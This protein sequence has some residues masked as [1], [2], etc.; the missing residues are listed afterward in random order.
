MTHYVLDQDIGQSYA[1]YHG[2]ST[3]VI[4][5]I[6]DGEVHL[7]ISS[8]PFSDQY[9][10]SPSPRDFGNND[11]DGPFFAQMAYL[12]PELYRVTQPGRWAIVHAKD[13][14][15]YGSKAVD[16]V[17]EIEPF[18]DRCIV[19]MRSAGFKFQGRITVATDPVR[20]N[21]QTNRLTHGELRKDSSKMGVGMPEYL[22]LFRRPPSDTSK[23]YSD[24]PVTSCANTA[25]YSLARWQL[26]AASDWRS[27]GKRLLQPYE[28]DGYD[29][30]AH[31][32]HLESL[33]KR[34]LLGRANGQRRPADSPW[35]WWDIQ[36]TDVLN[37]DIQRANGEPH[38]CPLMLDLIGRCIQRWSNASELVFD[39]F[40]GI[41]SVPYVAVQQGR[42]G[43]GIE[44]KQQYF[45]VAAQFLRG[46]ELAQTQMS[47]FEE[48]A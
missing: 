24:V 27:D 43:V 46:V 25:E 14:I 6:G 26:D 47:M 33:D 16:G 48:A 32:A 11:G 40:G 13:R 9:S 3:E 21:K 36:R 42:R 5:G 41:G 35:L 7:S 29:Y 31:V 4:K 37:A 1:Y 39:Y 20:E 23:Q 15:V 28:I 22:L 45:D 8:W 10:Y 19:A 17:M 38:I 2:D 30:R 34:G 44:L 18:S 12:L